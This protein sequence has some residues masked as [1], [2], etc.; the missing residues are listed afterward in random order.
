MK[1]ITDF[2]LTLGPAEFIITILLAAAYLI[3][4]FDRDIKFR[5]VDKK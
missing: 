3:A 1:A 5:K 4:W 2:F